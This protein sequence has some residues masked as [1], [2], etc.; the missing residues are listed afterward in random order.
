MIYPTILN[1]TRDNYSFDLTQIP[2]RLLPP[3]VVVVVEVA[4]RVVV[5]VDVVVV[6]S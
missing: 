3:V 2:L 1:I 4:K 6:E 5:V